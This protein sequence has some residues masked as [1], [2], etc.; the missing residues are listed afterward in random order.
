MYI[1]AHYA[2]AD[3]AAMQQFIEQHPFAILF[4]QSD[5]SPV[6]THLPFLL[7]RDASPSGTLLGHVARQNLQWEQ[8]EGQELLC[9]FHG[10]HAYISPSW[11]RA[12]KTVPTWNYVAVHAYGRAR[13]IG[14]P[15]Q[16]ISLLEQLTE[17]SERGMPQPW[18]F[19]PDDPLIQKLATQIVGFRIDIERLEGKW[20]LNQNHPRERRRR[21]ISAL[22]EIGGDSAIEI[23]KLME[24]TLRPE[25]LPS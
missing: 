15:R 20:K 23:A 7:D 6:A 3:L 13:L 24:E 11:Y 18:R 16:L 14:E 17:V 4:S 1:P 8:L 22:Q 5:G 2:N 19:D 10:P 9:V 21:V 12:E 25:A